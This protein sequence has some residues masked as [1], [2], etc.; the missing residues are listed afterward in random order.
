MSGPVIELLDLLARWI[1]VIAGIMWV[2]N[3]LLFN[4]LDRS[5]RS[6]PDAD[7]YGDIWLIHSGGFY[8]VE[9]NKGE[10]SVTGVRSLPAPLHWFK[11]QAYTTWLS[12]AALL[13]VVYYLGERALLVDPAVAEISPGAGTAIAVGTIVSAWILYEVVWRT[14]GER[15]PRAAGALSLVLLVAAIEVLLWRLSARAAWVHAGAMLGTLMAG[16]VVFTIMPSQRELV[17]SL[18]AGREPSQE[19]AD[20]AKTRSIH[21]NY[22]TFPVIV[23]MVSGHFPSLYARE[24]NDLAL[25]TLIAGG[26]AVRHVLNVRFTYRR[27]PWALAGTIVATLVLL[28][29][30]LGMGM[31]TSTRG[32]ATP[33]DSLLN[34][35]GSIT[36]EDARRVIDRRCASCHSANPADVSLGVMPGGVA[37]DTPEQIRALVPRILERAVVTRTMPPGNK[38]RMTESERVLLD[39]WIAIQRR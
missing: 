1:H 25:L 27:W 5:L 37:F 38:T 8:L 11:W 2:G 20:R 36:L 14:L 30:Q 29:A 34:V 12:G 17:E 33:A 18:S 22:L 24:G 15:A 10:R 28:G 9:K 21:N 6:R 13:I 26:A 3:S 19:I 35:G 31:F 32:A 23:L 7:I 4:W 39:S 16:N